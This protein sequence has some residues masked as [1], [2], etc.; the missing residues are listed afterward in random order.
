MVDAVARARAAAAGV[1]DPEIPVL[2]VDDLGMLRDVVILA[3]GGVEV[4]V[5]PTFLGCPATQTIAGD[6]RAAVL[7]AGF[8]NCRVR[9]ELSPPWSPD[10][11]T[12]EGHRKLLEYGIAPPRP[13]T[14]ACPQCG[15]RQTE[16]IS[17]F[18]ST[19]CKSLHRCLSCREPFDA[20]K[21]ASVALSDR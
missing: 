21:C 10:R 16:T 3:D 9:T 8:S 17:A 2:T 6:I 20:F 11:I 14:P 1:E 12:P 7:A 4:T 19:L 13:G 15:S 5:T 18:G